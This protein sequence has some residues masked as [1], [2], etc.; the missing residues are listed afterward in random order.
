MVTG[1]VIPNHVD[2]KA[3]AAHLRDEKLI[4]LGENYLQ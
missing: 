4:F 1:G 2:Y 3:K